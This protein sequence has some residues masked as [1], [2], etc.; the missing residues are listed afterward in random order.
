MTVERELGELTTAVK[1]LVKAQDRSSKK[2]DTMAT[3]QAVLM[4]AHERNKKL[5]FFA[6]TTALSAGFA[7]FWSIITTGNIPH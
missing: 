5:S 6:I 2:L 1:V 4:D 7:A 3:H